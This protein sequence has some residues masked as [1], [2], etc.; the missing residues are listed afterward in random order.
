MGT[1]MLHALQIQPQQQWQQQ[2][3]RMLCSSVSGLVYIAVASQGSGCIAI[4]R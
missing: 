3:L 1:I 2:Q 4:A